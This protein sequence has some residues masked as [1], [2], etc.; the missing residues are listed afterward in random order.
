MFILM[1]VVGGSGYTADRLCD[2]A[3]AGVPMEPSGAPSSVHVPDLVNPRVHLC[4]AVMTERSHPAVTG[5]MSW[6]TGAAQPAA[7]AR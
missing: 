7:M 4:R 3:I 1:L 5:P 2:V 6:S